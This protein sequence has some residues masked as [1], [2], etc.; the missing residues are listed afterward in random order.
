LRAKL[1]KA[2][3]RASEVAEQPRAKV[4]DKH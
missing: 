1:S 4:R 3:E 2:I